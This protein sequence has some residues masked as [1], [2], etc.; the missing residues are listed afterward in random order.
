MMA[1][2]AAI[3]ASPATTLVR[4]VVRSRP[5]LSAPATPSRMN[6]APMNADRLSRSQSML[7]MSTPATINA[8][9]L[10]SANHQ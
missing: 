4:R 1:T 6:N 10:S 7:K 2:P 3:E 9:P 8:R 5:S